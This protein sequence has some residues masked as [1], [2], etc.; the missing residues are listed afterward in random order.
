[1]ILIILC[2]TRPA[3][4]NYGSFSKISEMSKFFQKSNLTLSWRRSLSHRN[5][6]HLFIEQ[7]YIFLYD[8]GQCHERVNN[9]RE[10]VLIFTYLRPCQTSTMEYIW[11]IVNDFQPLLYWNPHHR[12]FD[13]IVN[14]SLAR[15]LSIE[16][17]CEVG[18]LTDHNIRGT[19]RKNGYCR[20]Y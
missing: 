12:C 13:M 9:Y 18:A 6:V 19:D 8:R 15:G 10:K 4:E 20:I 2:N 14:S 17:E 1:M 5:Q 3:S 7:I 11:E 16:G